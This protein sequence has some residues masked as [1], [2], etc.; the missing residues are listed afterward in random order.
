MPV[1]VSILIVLLIIILIALFSISGFLFH[2]L[3][4]KNSHWFSKTAHGIINPNDATTSNDTQLIYNKEL[5]H[6]WDNFDESVEITSFD[7][8]KLFGRIFYAI[9]KSNN[10]VILAHGYRSNGYFDSAPI[11]QELVKNGFNCLV[12]D[13]RAHGQS[14]GTRITLGK[15]ESHD[16]VAW[17]TFLKDNQTVEQLFW[18]GDSM[19]AGTVLMAS[20]Q[21]HT[22]GMTGII[23]DCGYSDVPTLFRDILTNRFKVPDSLPLLTIINLISRLRLGFNFKAISP[24]TNLEKN[25]V[26]LLLIHGQKDLFVPAYMSLENQSATNGPVET[27]FIEDAGHF[28]SH[29]IARDEYFKTLIN[30]ITKSS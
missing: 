26:P 19:G 24:K 10:W 27:L 14:Q 25:T 20:P 30:F 5:I 18:F 28:Q 7:H 21:A 6:F 1:L 16:L 23:A 4:Y 3:T 13:Q 8:L 12:I 15:N 11:A 17:T 29:I 22:L 2:H 9:P